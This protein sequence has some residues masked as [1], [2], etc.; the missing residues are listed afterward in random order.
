M[1]QP[2][3]FATL[4]DL[5]EISPNRA[6]GLNCPSIKE[7]NLLTAQINTFC[8]VDYVSSDLLAN[9]KNK[10]RSLRKSEKS[11][12]RWLVKKARN[13]FK[14]NLYNVDNSLLDPKCC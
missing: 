10:I 9:V 4:N 8:L 6:G 11:R 5:N 3:Y 1:R 14:S 7:K 12:R 13:Y 2:T